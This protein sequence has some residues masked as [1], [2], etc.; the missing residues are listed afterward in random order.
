MSNCS[1]ENSCPIPNDCPSPYC[2][3]DSEE[4][5]DKILD[6][7]DD[8]VELKELLSDIESEE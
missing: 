7:I 1:Y 3:F 6:L 2:K 4:N 8:Y 5:A